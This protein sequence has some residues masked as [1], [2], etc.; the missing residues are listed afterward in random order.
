MLVGVMVMLWLL[1]DS[2]AL[3]AADQLLASAHV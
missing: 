2:K 3:D 1:R